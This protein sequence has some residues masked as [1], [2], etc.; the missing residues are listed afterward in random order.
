M[1]NTKKLAL[2]G[3]FVAVGVVC[4]AFYIPVGV[5]KIFPV[6]HFVNV[7]AAV[8][9]GPVYGVGMAFSTSLIRVLLGTGTLLAFPGSMVGAL[10]SGLLYK[11]FR[12]TTMA[13]LGEAVG[14]GILG[15]LLAYPVAA[16]LLSKEAALFGFVIPFSISSST[17]AV[18][19]AGFITV[20]KKVKA[21]KPVFQK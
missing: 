2:S 21:F 18:I 3:I 13:L 5:A 4:S 14:T 1:S 16:L 15:A 20:I 8:L 10:L 11:K 7:L 9:L 19:A 17:G 6:Q 12:K